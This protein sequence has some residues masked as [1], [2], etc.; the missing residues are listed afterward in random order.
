[1]TRYGQEESEEGARREEGR[2]KGPGREE[3]I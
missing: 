1:V 2:D 3:V